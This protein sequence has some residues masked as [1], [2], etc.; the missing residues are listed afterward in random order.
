MANLDI[1]NYGNKKRACTV[2]MPTQSYRGETT[3]RAELGQ[4]TV[5]TGKTET[6]GRKRVDRMDWMKR[7]GHRLVGE[8][9][10]EIG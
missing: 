4:R 8:G 1:K 5:P 7:R 9:G 6:E 3:A 10:M 2:V